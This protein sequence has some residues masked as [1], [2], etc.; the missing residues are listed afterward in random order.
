MLTMDF[1]DPQRADEASPAPGRSPT[2]VC[3]LAF[4]GCF[5]LACALIR[6]AL[7][8]PREE[9]LTAKLEAF[10]PIK[11]RFDTLF[12]GSSRIYRHLDCAQ[13]DRIMANGGY[14]TS[15]FNFGVPGMTLLETTWVLDQVLALEPGRVERI[16]LSGEIALQLHADNE[17]S[18]RVVNWHDGVRTRLAVDLVLEG[19]HSLDQKIPIL[20]SHVMALA[21]NLVN[22]GRSR[23]SLVPG[24][25]GT[26]LSR[27]KARKRLIDQV[28]LD[29]FCSL[30]EYAGLVK[31]DVL[32]TTVARSIELDERWDEFV[33][34]RERVR[35]EGVANREP[36]PAELAVMD[37]VL[38][39]LGERGIEVVFVISPS[40]D[41]RE[42]YLRGADDRDL[43][44][45]VYDY[46]SVAAY[47][48]FFERD[49]RY[50]WNHLNE[51]GARKL[52]SM[53]AGRYAA[54][55]R[56]RGDTP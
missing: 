1:V 31:G 33:A 28:S 51:L 44:P 3:L 20:H 52:T 41:S 18:D 47:G 26:E 53:I 10:T 32:D 16:F 24:I 25:D 38:D 2:V 39:Q 19:P 43:V 27:L 17:L 30:D 11:D 49:L 15:S 37:R 5:V 54:M 42:G 55:R 40:Y 48:E 35:V 14:P 50:D 46:G 7:P 21:Y 12:L 45:T 23:L 8:Q 13:F 56:D 36:T 22:V 6:A 4:L 29:G 9:L 34:E